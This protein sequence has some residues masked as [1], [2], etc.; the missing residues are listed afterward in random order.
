MRESRSNV[1]AP[2]TAE[3]VP[4]AAVAVAAA[5]GVLMGDRNHAGY[6]GRTWVPAT[7]RSWRAVP[8]VALP[9][10]SDEEWERRAAEQ[11]RGER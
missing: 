2:R 11:K 1:C 4:A 10:V 9:Q 5:A 3:S 7:L 6:R 8:V